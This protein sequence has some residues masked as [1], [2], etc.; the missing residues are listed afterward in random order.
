MPIA[1]S[2]GDVHVLGHQ[3]SWILPVLGLSLVAAVISYIAGIGAARR[4]GA[5]LASFIGMAEVLF[6]ILFAWLL[7]GQLPTLV[8]FLGGAFILAGVAMV[9]LDELWPGRPAG[10]PAAP[11]RALVGRDRREHGDQQRPVR[12][13]PHCLPVPL[14]GVLAVGQQ[15]AQQAGVL[16]G[17]AGHEPGQHRAVV[18][19][20]VQR[21]AHPAGGQAGRVHRSVGEPVPGPLPGQHALG[22]EPGHDGDH[23]AVGKLAPLRHGEALADLAGAERH[24]GRP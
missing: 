20:R 14:P 3:V 12:Q 24:A 1:A 4:L 18:R 17:Q 13:Q 23:G 11:S 5:K 6:A 22:M 9:R 21:P 10:P 2:T 19:A 15:P 7:L 16:A 8:Q